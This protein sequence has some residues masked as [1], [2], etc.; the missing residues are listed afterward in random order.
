MKKATIAVLIVAVL[1]LAAIFVVAQRGGFGG[2]HGAMGGPGMGMPFRGLDLSDEQKAQVKQIM[3]ASHEKLKPVFE[4]LKA[5]RD[6]LKEATKAGAFDEAAVTAIANEQG[7]LHAQMIV[8]RQ[9]TMSQIYAILTDEQKAKFAEI[10]DK[11]P[12]GFKGFG[13]RRG[14]RGRPHS[15]FDKGPGVEQPVEN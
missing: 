9:R 13:D 5:N 6:K 8:E 1:G 7:S 2:K 3:V 12:D 11:G 14:H 15:G 4:A 10:R